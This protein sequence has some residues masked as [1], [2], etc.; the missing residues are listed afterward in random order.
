[1][2]ASSSK[3]VASSITLSFS[4]GKC[5]HTC[6]KAISPLGME[7]GAKTEQSTS[8]ACVGGGVV[9]LS[10]TVCHNVSLSST[11]LSSKLSTGFSIAVSSVSTTLSIPL[12]IGSSSLSSIFFTVSSVLKLALCSTLNSGKKGSLISA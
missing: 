1:M 8:S 6:T 10:T 11:P 12:A 5:A 7:A 3:L 9:S 4:V 2:L